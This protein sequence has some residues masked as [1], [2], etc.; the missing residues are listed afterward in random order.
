LGTE[1]TDLPAF[2]HAVHSNERLLGCLGEKGIARR[3]EADA[4]RRTR[5]RLTLDDTRA[6]AVVPEQQEMP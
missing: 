6:V 3:R 2:R 1:A 5:V 4:R